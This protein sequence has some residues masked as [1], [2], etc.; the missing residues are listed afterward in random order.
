M[1]RALRRLRVQFSNSDCRRVYKKVAFD[2]FH[3]PHT[4]SFA[5]SCEST[6]S[7]ESGLRRS[8]WCGRRSRFGG[9][10]GGNSSPKGDC[11][12]LPRFLRPGGKDGVGVRGISDEKYALSS[13][14]ESVLAT[15]APKKKEKA[16]L[17]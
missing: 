4:P 7:T 12:R 1:N 15:Y 11:A 10:W 14:S 2:P 16:D 3:T 17:N 6:S 8:S 13:G 9:G 5:H